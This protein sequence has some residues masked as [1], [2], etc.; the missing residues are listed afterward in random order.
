MVPGAGHET[1]RLAP[2]PGC[3]RIARARIREV[4]QGLGLVVKGL[5]L[6]KPWI[7]A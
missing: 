6:A 4:P 5:A 1:H 7:D 2:H 3:Q